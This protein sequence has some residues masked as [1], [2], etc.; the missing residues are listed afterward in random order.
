MND[1]LFFLN[2]LQN[3]LNVFHMLSFEQLLL[4]IELCAHLHPLILRKGRVNDPRLP[5]LQLKPQMRQF[6][7][8][9]LS[10]RG[11]QID[12]AIVDALW[13]Q[14]SRSIWSLGHRPASKAL[15]QIFLD[16]G[17]KYEI[18]ERLCIC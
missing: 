18:G 2:A 4:F 7:A 13:T 15:L 17:T 16:Y 5:P 14:L 12:E 8:D 1:L 9:A 11:P 6:L 3:G 10:S